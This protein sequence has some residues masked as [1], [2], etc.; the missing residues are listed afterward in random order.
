M[1][2]IEPPLSLIIIPWSGLESPTAASPPVPLSL[3]APSAGLVPGPPHHLPCLS[4]GQASARRVPCFTWHTTHLQEG[5]CCLTLMV[6]AGPG[7]RCH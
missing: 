2:I 7:Y 4:L 6:P 1:K 5:P 3:P